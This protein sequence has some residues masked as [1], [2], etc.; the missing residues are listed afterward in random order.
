[1]Y[2]YAAVVKEISFEMMP[3]Q[4]EN[5]NREV[6]HENITNFFYFIIVF[7]PNEIYNRSIVT[8]DGSLFHQ[9]S[10]RFCKFMNNNK[11]LGCFILVLLLSM[12]NIA[13][14]KSIRHRDHTHRGHGEHTLRSG[15]FAPR[16]Y[17]NHRHHHDPPRYNQRNWHWRGVGPN[18]SFYRG[19]RLP[20]KYCH[21]RYVIGNWYD[22][23]HLSAPPLGYHWVRCSSDFILIAITTGIILEILLER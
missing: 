22:Y 19:D 17:Q 23:H 2:R 15:K 11:K 16:T 12:G 9:V 3:T 20:E 10:A 18:H 21:R 4:C 8:N 7:V 6:S 5:N 14:A 13:F 1:M